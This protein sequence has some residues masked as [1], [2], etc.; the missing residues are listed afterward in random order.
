M[1]QRPQPPLGVL[2]AGKGSHNLA[3][4]GVAVLEEVVIEAG[5]LWKHV[6]VRD[7]EVEETSLGQGCRSLSVA[8]L[9]FI[10]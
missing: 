9:L 10:L 8:S 7:D 5:E 6:E 3:V 2:A 1:R 4:A